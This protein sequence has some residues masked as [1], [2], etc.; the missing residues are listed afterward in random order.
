MYELL[1]STVE[2]CRWVA[3]V[4]ELNVYVFG[5]V[6]E[7]MENKATMALSKRFAQPCKFQCY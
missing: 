3:Y 7:G 1:A 2:A 6:F 4:L 5:Q